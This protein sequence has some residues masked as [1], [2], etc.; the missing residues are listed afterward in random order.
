MTAKEKKG[1][2]KQLFSR[3]SRVEKKTRKPVIIVGF[4]SA[5]GLLLLLR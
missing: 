1:G 4:I 2:K 3:R 5:E